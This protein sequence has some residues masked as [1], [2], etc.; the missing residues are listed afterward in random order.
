M[1]RYV[2]NSPLLKVRK[3]RVNILII[4]LVYA[5]HT[6]LMSKSNMD[7]YNLAY[8]MHFWAVFALKTAISGHDG[9]IQAQ[10][11]LAGYLKGRTLPPTTIKFSQEAQIDKVA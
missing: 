4:S 1:D 3:Y 9:R 8:M 11:G 5:L 2:M 10:N 7:R 6:H